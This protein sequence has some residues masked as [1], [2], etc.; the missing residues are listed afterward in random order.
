MRRVLFVLV[1]LGALLGQSVMPAAAQTSVGYRFHVWHDGNGNG[2]LDASGADTCYRQSRNLTVYG[3]GPDPI[4]PLYFITL[5]SLSNFNPASASGVTACIQ[6]SMST[7]FIKPDYSFHALD[8]A[9][10]AYTD[11]VSGSGTST[12]YVG[13]QIP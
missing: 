1:L 10:G 2:V 4:Q 5:G 7:R 12:F 3:T 13:I 9:T 8:N 6:V 11:F